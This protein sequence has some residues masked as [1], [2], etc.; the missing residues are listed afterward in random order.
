[1]PCKSLLFA[2]LVFATQTAQAQ[3]PVSP[4][5]WLVAVEAKDSGDKPVFGSGILLTRTGLV[6]T[7]WQLV[8][9]IDRVRV[10]VPNVGVFQ[11]TQAQ[12]VCRGKNLAILQLDDFA[13]KG[14]NVETPKLDAALPSVGDKLDL[15]F[16]ANPTR[17]VAADLGGN[18]SR[19]LTGEMAVDSQTVIKNGDPG[20]DRDATWLRIETLFGSLQSG[21][22]VMQ[23]ETLQAIIVTAPNERDSLT[24]A[25]HVQHVA[26]LLNNPLPEPVSLA[27]LQN[28][29]DRPLENLPASNVSGLNDTLWERGLPVAER[30]QKFAARRAL[31]AGGVQVADERLKE[32]RKEISTRTSQMG[33]LKNR[34]KQIE[35]TLS[36]IKPIGTVPSYTRNLTPAEIEDN[37]RDGGSRRTTAT[38]PGWVEWDPDVVAAAR[39]LA[40][41][42]GQ[43]AAE[44]IKLN[45]EVNGLTMEQAIIDFEHDLCLNVVKHSPQQLWQIADAA[46]HRPKAEHE[47][48]LD[49]WT[50]LMGEPALSPAAMVAR[51]WSYMH[52]GR[53]DDAEQDL[54]AA[55]KYPAVKEV[56]AASI[57]RLLQRQKKKE[58]ADAQLARALPLAKGNLAAAM[59]LALAAREKGDHAQCRQLLERC[60]E[61]GADSAEAHRLA[62]LLYATGPDNIRKANSALAHARR[63][64]QLTH[65]QDELCLMALAAAEAEG[66]LFAAGLKHLDQAS[67]LCAGDLTAQCE[68]W[69]VQLQAG[70]AVRIPAE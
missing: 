70:K 43:L 15:I 44:W 7:D 68:A 29:P 60:C 69:K 37:K 16:I 45:G 61:L 65:A 18:V 6:A 38:V 47:A 32:L 33:K 3:S 53:L 57:A 17:M 41:E 1:M 9:G 39:P 10:A 40:A 52:L 26:E 66:R 62:A 59:V 20:F 54:R 67:A 51:S 14:A 42:Y 48:A 11:A 35:D 64:V 2:V 34:G 4:P 30:V 46:G 22:A 25:L 49:Q 27:K 5:R 56:C 19:I 12:A 55:Y 23:G 31:I 58:Q 21:G 63:A 24:N 28:V 8:A 50:Q 36:K 13:M